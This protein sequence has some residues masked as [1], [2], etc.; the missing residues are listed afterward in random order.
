M[1][2]GINV[3]RDLLWLL[4]KEC[5]NHIIKRKGINKVLSTSPLN[6]KGI[7]SFR[8]SG[9]VQK[10]ALTVEAH[11]S[12]KGV[13]L[14]YKSKSPRPAKNIVRIPFTKNATQSVW[15]IKKFVSKNRYR[16]D[17]K[18]AVLRKASAI[19]KSQIPRTIKKKGAKAA[20]KE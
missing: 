13:N 14:I 3:S 8:H 11:P 20:K 6:P 10:R 12:G 16:R 18:G 5:N 1:P 4:T 17:L 19:W 7:A 2:A 9:L 15:K